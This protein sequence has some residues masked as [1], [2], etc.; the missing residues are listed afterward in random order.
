MIGKKEAAAKAEAYLRD[1][2]PAA[3]AI[4]L[5]EVD[6][7]DDR[8]QIT[9]SFIPAEGS[10]SPTAGRQYKLFDITKDSGEVRSMKIRTL[11]NVWPD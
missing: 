5:E 4:R 10:T 7:T 6:A 3:F 2:F 8:W 1:L 11:N 9:L